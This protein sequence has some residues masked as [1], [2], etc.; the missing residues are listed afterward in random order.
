MSAHLN[1]IVTDTLHPDANFRDPAYPRAN[2]LA[3]PDVVTN[4]FSLVR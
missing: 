4:K 2:R 1:I 3:T